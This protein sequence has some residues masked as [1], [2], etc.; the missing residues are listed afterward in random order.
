M[1]SC[2]DV[3]RRLAVVGCAFTRWNQPGDSHAAPV[4]C[5]APGTGCPEAPISRGSPQDPDGGLT[6]GRGSLPNGMSG[7]LSADLFL[8]S[9]TGQHVG[10]PA[11]HGPGSVGAG[12]PSRAYAV[13]HPASAPRLPRAERTAGLRGSQGSELAV[14]SRAP[15][16]GASRCVVSRAAP[17]SP[18]GGAIAPSH[19]RGA[20][21]L[22]PPVPTSALPSLLK[23]SQDR[24]RSEAARRYATRRLNA[25]R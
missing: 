12:G 6:R 25:V 11:C 10:G 17:Q 8:F 20:K 5:R 21:M 15:A 14:G 22:T 19:Q 23:K 4:P 9:V 18:T 7:F 13:R 1:P 24:F 2:C 16:A 3:L